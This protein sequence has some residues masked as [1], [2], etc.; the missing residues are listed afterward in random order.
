VLIT[1]DLGS[2]ASCGPLDFW[3]NSPGYDGLTVVSML[4][5]RIR[6][7]LPHR[8]HSLIALLHVVTA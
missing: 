5:P 8:M 6:H 1:T 2:S 3:E 4:Q 7:S